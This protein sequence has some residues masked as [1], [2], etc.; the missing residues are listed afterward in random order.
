MFHGRPGTAATAM[1]GETRRRK[2]EPLESIRNSIFGGRKK[3][4]AREP[5]FSGGP[6]S[7]RG[8]NEFNRPRSHFRNEDDCE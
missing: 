3:S 1:S 5:S 8:N 4:D 2:T 6:P 7:S